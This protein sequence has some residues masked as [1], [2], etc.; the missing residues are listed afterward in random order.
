MS[1]LSL[2]T[3][4]HLAPTN[5]NST[6]SVH[7]PACTDYGL[8]AL[9]FTL[10]SESLAQFY[11]ITDIAICCT[12]LIAYFWLKYFENVEEK[13]LDSNTGTYVHI[14]CCK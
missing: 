11:S 9:Q 1:Q 2:T 13:S 3:A 12:I 6:I 5:A 8:Y 4:G 10:N 7:I 14:N